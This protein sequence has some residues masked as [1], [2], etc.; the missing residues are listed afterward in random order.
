MNNETLKTYQDTRANLQEKGK[1]VVTQQ[2]QGL[3]I[4]MTGMLA[5]GGIITVALL[6]AGAWA[7]FNNQ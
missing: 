7:L 5:G 1:A 3:P 6:V 2:T 4:D